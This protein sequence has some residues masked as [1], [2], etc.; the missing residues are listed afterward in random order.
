MALAAAAKEGSSD[1]RDEADGGR[2]R[3]RLAG[4][5]AAAVVLMYVILARAQHS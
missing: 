2:L 3:V 5:A 1:L 4:G